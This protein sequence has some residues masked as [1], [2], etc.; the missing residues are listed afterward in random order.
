MLEIYRKNL[1]LSAKTFNDCLQEILT[2]SNDKL[3][4]ELFTTHPQYKLNFTP[5][6]SDLDN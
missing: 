4:F 2:T 1:K 5:I 3:S 6:V